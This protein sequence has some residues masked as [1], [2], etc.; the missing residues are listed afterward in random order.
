MIPDSHKPAREESDIGADILSM[1]EVNGGT[2]MGK[3]AIDLNPRREPR[4]QALSSEATEELLPDRSQ[5]ARYNLRRNLP[6]SQLL[7]KYVC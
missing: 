4:D 2:L 3:S 7:K 6:P 1:S 5:D